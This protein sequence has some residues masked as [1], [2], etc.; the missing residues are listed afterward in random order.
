MKRNI[1][2][3]GGAQGIGKITVLELAKNG[4][5]V[6][7]FDKDPEALSE[8]KNEVD[9]DSIAFFETDISLEKS[10]KKSIAASLHLFGNIAGLINNAAI[11]IDKPITHLSLDEWNRVLATN[12]TGAF[13]CSKHAVSELKKS[14]GRI[15]NISSTRALQSE[16]N[17]EAYSTS[18]GG[19]LAFTHSLA[20]SLGPEIKVNSICPGWIDVST[21]RKQSK[22]E[23]ANLT[24]A[25]HLQHPAGRV[26]KAK[27]ISNMVLFLLQ[28]E[29][30]F[31]T[32]QNFVIDGGITKKMIYV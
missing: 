21:V 31:I 20:I 17:T 29:N 27:D 15:I 4:F 32:G 2:V 11:L 16:P 10:V 13:L 23:A 7:V 3:T 18:K 8:F 14:K 19:I 30:D 26:G 5:G 1:I 22:T 24:K 25:D 12:L 9:S 28:A 6:S